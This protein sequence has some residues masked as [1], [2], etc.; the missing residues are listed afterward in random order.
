MVIHS[1]KILASKEEATTS[2]TRNRKYEGKVSEKVVLIEGWSLRHQD[3]PSA[4][5]LTNYD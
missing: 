1:P 2:F 3:G 4:M 5:V